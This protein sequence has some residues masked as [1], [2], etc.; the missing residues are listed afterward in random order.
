MTIQDL[1]TH[2]SAYPAD[3]RVKAEVIDDVGHTTL[4]SIGCMAKTVKADGNY[5]VLFLEDAE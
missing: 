2:L 1:I 4:H 5:V 3:L